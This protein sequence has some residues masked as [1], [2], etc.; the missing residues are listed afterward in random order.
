MPN[1]KSVRELD[2][3]AR[4]LFARKGREAGP[5]GR[6]TGEANGVK[7]RRVMQ[8]TR[9]LSARPFETLRILDLGC[10]DG[11][12]AVEAGL[13]GAHVLALDARR[14]RMDLGAACAARHGLDR[15]RFVQE[16]VRRVTRQE[17]GEFDIVYFL[18]LLYHLDAPDVFSVLERIHE[19]CGRMLVVDTLISL[20]A[21]SDVTWRDRVYR[22][23]PYREHE[24]A[25]SADVRRGRILRS[26]DNTFSFRLTRESLVRVLHDVGFTSV[27]ECYVP[28]EPGKPEER[29]TMVALKG[30]PVQLSTYPWV[31]HTSE[32][33]IEA[34]LRPATQLEP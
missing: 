1:E 11:V 29:I 23:Q 8:I 5:R 12:Y 26:I 13:H 31:N 28:F 24:D 17:H 14:D 33:E 25:D 7:V 4:A 6:Q 3:E 22:G 9:D 15:V 27:F 16:D 20:T 32:A 10:G 21:E 18:G 2:A 19:L 34:R 30:A